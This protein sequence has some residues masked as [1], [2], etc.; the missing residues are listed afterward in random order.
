M[1]KMVGGGGKEDAEAQRTVNEERTGRDMAGMAWGGDASHWRQCDNN[2][3]G[4]GGQAFVQVKVFRW[5]GLSQ[6]Y[7]T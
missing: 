4:R 2:V 6:V 1:S 7:R 3:D 5:R